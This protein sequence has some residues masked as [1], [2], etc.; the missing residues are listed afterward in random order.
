M[1]DSN[2][3]YWIIRNSW[4]SGWGMNGY[5]HLKMYPD[6][7]SNDEHCGT[8]DNPAD[9]SGCDNGPATVPVCG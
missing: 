2:D 4:G 7:P 5:V 6:Q 3:A 8:D 1:S 9:G